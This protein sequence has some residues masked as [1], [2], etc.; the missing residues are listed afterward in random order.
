MAAQYMLVPMTGGSPDLSGLPCF[1]YALG[2]AWGADLGLYLISGSAAQLA[3]IAA[4]A[5]V[6]P[7]ANPSQLGSTFSATGRSRINAYLATR[8]LAPLAAGGTYRTAVEALGKRANPALDLA[9][10]AIREP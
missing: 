8:G 2:A 7:L 9:S 6:G 1:G 10:L 3:A 5:Q 4:L